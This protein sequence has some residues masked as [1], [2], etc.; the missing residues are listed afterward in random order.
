VVN[1]VHSGHRQRLK[2]EFLSGG[3]G[4]NTPDH[5]WLELLLFYCIVQKDTNELAHRLIDKFGSL[6][7]VFEAPAE[8]LLKYPGITESN[9]ALLKMVIPIARKCAI[10]KS[11][12]LLKISNPDNV[13]HYLVSKYYGLSNERFSIVCV[14]QI[15]K[16]IDFKFLSDGDIS[17]VGLSTRDLIKYVLEKNCYCAVIAH[18]HP[19]GFALPSKSDI[20]STIKVRNVLASVNVKLLDHIIISG[21]DFVSLAQS[22][23]Y[24]DIFK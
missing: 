15:G 10:E 17:T 21:K 9:I 7:G 16:I 1:N 8:E 23:E 12:D 3:F 24:Y 13:G 4:E 2:D 22:K 14:N 5:K 19:N 20:D 6:C 11:N 18:N